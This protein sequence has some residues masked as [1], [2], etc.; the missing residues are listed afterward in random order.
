M[1]TVTINQEEVITIHTAV[2]HKLEGGPREVHIFEGKVHTVQV[3]TINSAMF[4]E[5]FDVEVSSGNSWGEDSFT[6]LATVQGRSA[7]W[8]IVEVFLNEKVEM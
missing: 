6:H 3:T 2:H 4:R 1:S 5:E 8:L 7:L